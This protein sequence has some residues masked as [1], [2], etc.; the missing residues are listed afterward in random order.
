MPRALTISVGQFSDQGRKDANQD[1][2]GALIPGE[3][4]LGLKGIAVVLA[5]GIS[6]SSVG[7]IAAESAVKSFLTDYYCTS[8]SWSVKS[9]A[10]RVLEATNSWLHAQTRRSQNPYDKDKGYVCTLS[11]LVIR[12][13]TAHLF[14]VGDSRI[15]R[16]AGNSLEQLTNDH[17]VVISSQQSYLGRA[18]GV[19]PQLEIDYQALPLERGDIFLLVTDG[20][21]EHVPARQLAKTIKDGAADLDVAAKSIVEQAYE[22][23]SPDNLTVQIVR[24]DELPD[25]DAGEVFGQP[26]ELPLPPLLDARMLFDGYRIVRELHASHR[27]HIYLAVD[28]DSATTVTIKIPSIDLRDDPA[29]LKRFMMEEWVARRIDSPH[30]LKPFLP[31]RKR[32]F[33]YVTM[34]YIDGQTLTQWITDNPT[35]ALETVRGITEQIAKGLRAF[36]RKEMLHQDVRPDNIMIDRTGTVKIIDFGS[37]RIAGV[38]EAAPAG[39]E[40]IL[41]TQ[42]YTAPEYFLGEGGTA[43]SDLFSLGVVTY[44]ML[45][46]RLPYGAQIARARTRS[47]FNRLVYRP[48]AHRGREIPGWVDGA[49]ERAVHANPLKRYESFSE[50]LFDLRN[51][52]AKYL[53]TSSTPLIERNPVLFWKSTTLLLALVVVLLLAYGAHHWR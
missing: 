29:Y 33:L 11:A 51:P 32:N 25:G 14:H 44:Q 5:D 46:G 19:N 13:T 41:G 16:V 35:P 17:R 43:R 37:T 10:Q 18:L 23:G 2:H 45:T 49:L 21:Y 1:F 12:S 4:L 39:V 15:Y 30:V 31:Q 42:Q 20:I 3:P 24:I 27:S 28:E 26:T 40:D 38:A 36:H 8:E 7:R 50:F 52:N 47:D 22:N 6:S 48:A 9:S 34:E 53:T